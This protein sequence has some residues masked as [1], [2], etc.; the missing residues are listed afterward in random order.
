MRLSFRE[1]AGSGQTRQAPRQPPGRRSGEGRGPHGVRGVSS[2]QK[3]TRRTPT[4]PERRRPVWGDGGG[5]G[6]M[7][8]DSSRAPDTACR[9][10]ES[11]VMA[12]IE[13]PAGACRRPESRG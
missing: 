4:D 12:D 13:Q 10:G 7:R 3:R 8:G 6:H 11:Y 1:K 2:A 9:G 5:R